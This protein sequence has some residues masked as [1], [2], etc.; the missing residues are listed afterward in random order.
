MKFSKQFLN[1]LLKSAVTFHDNSEKGQNIP[2]KL[3]DIDSAIDHFSKQIKFEANKAL[4]T[5]ILSDSPLLHAVN[6]GTSNPGIV[7]DKRENKLVIHRGKKKKKEMTEEEMLKELEKKAERDK[8]REEKKKEKN[9][10]KEKVKKQKEDIKTGKK[11]V[12]EIEK[13]SKKYNKDLE[14]TKKTKAKIQKKVDK[15]SASPEEKNIYSELKDKEKKLEDDIEDLDEKLEEEKDTLEKNQKE[16]DDQR[17]ENRR[18]IEERKKQREEKK[19]E[20]E[21]KRKKKREEKE[22]KI[23]EEEEAYIKQL[24]QCYSAE[25]EQDSEE[26]TDK[27]DESEDN[28]QESKVDPLQVKIYQ[29]PLPFQRH[30]DSLEWVRPHESLI[31]TLLEGKPTGKGSSLTIFH[32]P[33]GTGKTYKLVQ[34]LSEL[35]E[36]LPENSN[37]RF[38]VCAASNIGTGNLYTRAK[39]L[40]V[41]G[42]LVLSDTSIIKLTDEEQASFKPYSDKVIFT[43]VSM[44]YGNILNKQKFQTILIDEAAQCQESWTWG[45]LRDEVRHIYLAGDPMQLPAVVSK[46]GISFNYD[47]SLMARLMKL[48]Y[49]TTLLDTQRRM[50]PDIVKFS[51]ENFYEGKLKTDYK[52]PKNKLYKNIKP[53]EVIDVDGTEERIGTSYRNKAEA[54]KIMEILGELNIPNSVIICPYQ[55]QCSYLRSLLKKCKESN[56]NRINNPSEVQVHTI[57]SFQGR[58]SNCIILST[59]RSGD[60]MGFWDDHRRLNVALTRAKH[61]LRIVGNKK[62]W[63]KCNHLIKEI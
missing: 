50:H 25:N 31:P 35:L 5:E 51:N 59:V 58:E 14:K 33:P 32:G 11:T 63:E 21:E 6:L 34:T 17:E 46:E 20:N 61:I 15:G 45:L 39:S 19:K 8:K 60:K 18:I 43:T 26:T 4:Q 38:L 48:G 36:K 52:K 47:R 28:D 30:L 49:P 2:L 29:S 1:K 9:V 41:K 54:E 55:A 3:S 7:S 23:A 22:K 53:L 40:G 13:K 16:F 24:E 10:E 12:K 37:H 42:T 44:R 62:A 57:D 56:E 27:K